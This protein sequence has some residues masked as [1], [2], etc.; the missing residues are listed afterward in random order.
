VAGRF[1]GFGFIGPCAFR[2]E[3][4]DFF[5]HRRIGDLEIKKT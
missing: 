5:G 3:E 4:F 2:S 1:A